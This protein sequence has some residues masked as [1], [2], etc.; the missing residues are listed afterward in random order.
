VA[1]SAARLC[2][3]YDATVFRV[4]GEA[5]RRVAHH[6]T[7]STAT[8]PEE[9]PIVRES[10]AGRAVLERQTIHLADISAASPTEFPT[11]RASQGP[12]GIRTMLA[13]PL[14]RDGE[15]VGAI[16]LRRT[17]VRPFTDQQ[18][19]LLQTF[20][21]QAV[22]AIENTRLFSELQNT[23]RQLAQASQH[24]SEFLAN[25]S[26][27]LRTPL[28]GIIGFSEVQLDPSMPVD[29]AMRTQF[30]ENIY[31]SGQHLLTLINDILDLSKVEAGKMELHPEAFDLLDA[32]TG[33]HGVVKALVD[34]KQ[35]I[36]LLE[37]PGDLGSVSHDPGRF[38]QVLFNLLSNAV[39]FTPQGGTITTSVRVAEGWLEVAVKDTGIG[40]SPED[41]AKVLAEFQQID[42]GYARQQRGTGLGLA[43]VRNFVRLMG[44]DI[45]LRSALGEGSTFTV[46]LP[47]RKPAAAGVARAATSADHQR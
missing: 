33:V 25:M 1:E 18:M 31:Q 14:L 7:L 39:K 22:I 19:A 12:F 29:E 10:V 28:N 47:V 30:L 38:K 44:G 17:S 8:V 5:L 26:H 3:T 27:E 34:K 13:V 46:R 9:L 11:L 42:S 24:K 15:P 43:L 45:T 40:I 23:S 6:G 32:L 35:Q 21:D 20:A 4:D 16:G 36:L 41:H 37:A 2:D